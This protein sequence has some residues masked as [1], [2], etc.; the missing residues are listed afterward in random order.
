MTSRV[1]FQGGRFHR[2]SLDGSYV[3]NP[4]TVA[5]YVGDHRGLIGAAGKEAAAWAAIHV[6]ELPMIGE[7]E[8]RGLA[9]G[10]GPR[11]WRQAADHGTLVHKL[12]EPLVYGQPLPAED[13]QGLPYPEAA[14]QSAQQLARFMD[15]WHVDPIAH[16]AIVFHEVDRWAGRLDLLA[17]MDGALWLLDYTTSQS[18]VWPEK[19]LQLAAYAHATHI[20]HEGVDRP[21]PAIERAAAVWV[22]PDQWQ[23]VPLAVGDS[24]YD[25]FRHAMHVAAWCKLDHDQ[26][27]GAPLTAPEVA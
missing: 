24:V 20:V 3:P 7:A 12:A 22:R 2:Y 23:V 17:R 15:A 5:R 10:A 19:S 6:D 9:Q 25:V 13:D 27:V 21:M 1:T 16:E 14:Y 11:A 26:S 8:W 18:G 4:T